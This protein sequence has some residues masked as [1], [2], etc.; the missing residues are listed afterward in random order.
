MTPRFISVVFA[1]AFSLNGLGQATPA[2]IRDSL[3]SYIFRARHDWQIPGV[4]VCI[5]KDGQVVLAKGYGVKQIRSNDP[6]DENT[7][8]MIGSNTKAMTATAIAM[9]Q[10]QKK[11]SLNDK[12]TKHLHGFKLND[13]LT[14][15]ELMIS[16]LLSHRIGMETF[17]GDFMYWTSDLSTAQVLEK[18]G[19]LK[20]RYSFRSK[21]GYTNAG[22][23]AAGE[24]INRV[25]GK[26]WAMFLK[27]SIFTPLGMNHTIA[28]SADLA[29]AS[30]K[31]FPHSYNYDQQMVR[32]PFGDI[33]NLAP[34]GA[35]SSS[36]ADMSKWIMMQ[37]DN[38]K[39]NG[40]QIISAN[41]LEQTKIPFSIL[42]NGGHPFNKS[43]FS[44]YGLGWFLEEY[45]GRKIVSHTGGVNGFVTS[46][47]L[48]PEERLGIVVFTNTDQ[49]SFYEA[50]KWEII[51]AYLNLPYRN[52]SNFYLQYAKQQLNTSKKEWDLK[53]DSAA[54]NPK[55][56]LPLEKYTGAYQHEAYGKLYLSKVNDHLLMKLEHHPDLLG[57][58]LPLGG[59]RFLCTYSDPVFGRKVLSFT[60]A[61]NTIK[62]MTL[63]VA[64][65]VEF[66]PYEF[67]KL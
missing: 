64:D 45:S 21:W 9:L 38:G 24:I 1:L 27:D 66:T 29:T 30:N 15:R 25:T 36:V 19:K 22:F 16:D 6:V 62:S 51:D 3:D 34:A 63:R 44:L 46:V 32:I 41:A 31:A 58:L 67:I 26:T 14:T 52:Y 43:H 47:T 23:V 39:L 54:G 61:G 56:A 50:L 59:N 49:N 53:K 13:P 20:P 42:G 33:D 40:K 28:L 18:F 12:V 11:L 35:V 37:L 10:E 60:Q 2:F 65:F 8:F 17:Q 57:T 5:V 55:T 48:I 4:A 7:L